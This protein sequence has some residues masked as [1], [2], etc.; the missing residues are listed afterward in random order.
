LLEDLI[1]EEH[2]TVFDDCIFAIHLQRQ[3][4]ASRELEV[5]L[6]DNADMK[7]IQ[8][9]STAKYLQALKVKLSFFSI[10]WFKK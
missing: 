6:R 4:S 3:Y 7:G 1:V 8:D 9:A 5:F 10:D 2:V